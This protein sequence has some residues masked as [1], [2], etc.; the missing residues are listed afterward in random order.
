MPSRLIDLC[1]NDCH[2]SIFRTKYTFRYSGE[3]Y[4]K[5]MLISEKQ[6]IKGI[7]ERLSFGGRS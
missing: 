1:D 6:I 7:S 4:I 3:V 2:V 5:V